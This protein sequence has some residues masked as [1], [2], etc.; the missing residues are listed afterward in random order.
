M[1]IHQHLAARR[2]LLALPLVL[3]SYGGTAQAQKKNPYACK[4]PN[5]ES[6][7]TAANTCGSPSQPCSVASGFG[8]AFITTL[9]RSSESVRLQQY[10]TILAR[11]GSSHT[12]INKQLLDLL[13]LTVGN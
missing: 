9:F 8:L 5:P 3:L 1:T 11:A 13:Q 10:T 12:C 6:L 4:E 2:I 7:C